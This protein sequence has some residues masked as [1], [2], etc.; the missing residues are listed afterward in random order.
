MK[1]RYIG[2]PLILLA[3][4]ITCLILLPTETQATE[5]TS[6]TCGDNLT[7]VL[8]DDGT[9]TISG[10]GDMANYDENSNLAPWSAKQ[11]QITSVVI[12]DGVTSIGDSAIYNCIELT[13]VTIPAS[14]KSIGVGAF[15]NTSSL[16]RINITDL[17]AWCEIEFNDI[18]T[19]GLAAL[20]LN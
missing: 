15:R 8:A 6:G 17:A 4:C 3:I 1:K 2:I 7:W 11:D 16:E 9:L 10:T 14:V 12:E 13:S 18:L 5:A 20:Y 19:Y